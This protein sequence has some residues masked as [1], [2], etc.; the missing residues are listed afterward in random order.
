M[1]MLKGGPKGGHEGP[2]LIINMD[3]RY[4]ILLFLHKIEALLKYFFN[5]L[6]ID[7]YPILVILVDYFD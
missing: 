3:G 7:Y 1:Y 2:L 6:I 4:K 5:R